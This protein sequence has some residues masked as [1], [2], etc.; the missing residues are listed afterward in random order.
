M[1]CEVFIRWDIISWMH[2]FSF[3]VRKFSKFG[4]MEDGVGL[5]TNTAKIEPPQL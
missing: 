1:D 3:L 2:G 5:P 4:F